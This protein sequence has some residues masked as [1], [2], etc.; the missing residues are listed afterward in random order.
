MLSTLRQP[1]YLGL[2][3]LVLVIA[4]VCGLAGTWQAERLQEKREA[5]QRLRADTYDRPLEV[6][7]VLGRASA[8]VSDGAAQRFR[9]V[10]ATGVYLSEHET[11]LR[12]QSVGGDVGVLVL[13]P[14]R[15]SDGVLLVARGFVRQT[16]AATTTPPIPAS[17]PGTVSI[18]A[19]LEPAGSKPDQLGQLPGRQVESVNPVQ[20]AGRI[21]AP[22]WNGYAEL[23]AGQPGTA[24]LTSLPGPDLSNPAGGIEE[25]QHAAYVIQWYLFALLALGAPF[26]MAAAERRRDRAAE[27]LPI[28]AEG[29]DPSGQP[30]TGR[31][32]AKAKKASLDDRLAGRS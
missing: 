21:G 5:N 28:N 7:A 24:G 26:V 1:R 8:P 11:L 25:P 27:P 17:P 29:L 31:A 3:G 12:R 4:V 6:T 30:A 10:T 19:R 2:F 16:G 15:T 13:T 18:T 32:A 9:Q 23:L 14:L 22:V 20:Q